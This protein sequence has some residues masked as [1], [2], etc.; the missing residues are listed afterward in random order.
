MNY[1]IAKKI[2]TCKTKLSKDYNKVM[3]ARRVIKDSGKL[4]WLF[5][6]MSREEF[7]KMQEQY[8]EH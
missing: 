5:F 2:V 6:T 1:R 4:G 7:N 8:N 3:Q